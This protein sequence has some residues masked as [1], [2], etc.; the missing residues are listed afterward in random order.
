MRVNTLAPSVTTCIP[1]VFHA[2]ARVSKAK[3]MGAFSPIRR[4]DV[5]IQLFDGASISGASL[6]AE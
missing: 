6:C 2:A 4:P 1:T 3:N 5:R